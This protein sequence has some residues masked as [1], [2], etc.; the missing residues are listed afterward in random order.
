M[1]KLERGKVYFG[2]WRRP[3]R[4]PLQPPG[5][6]EVENEKPPVFEPEHDSLSESFDAKAARTKDSVDGRIKGAKQE[7]TFDR[8]MGKR[9]TNHAMSERLHVDGDI[10]E[11]WHEPKRTWVHTS[12]PPPQSLH[13]VPHT[14]QSRHPESSGAASNGGLEQPDH[15]LGFS[16]AIV[17]SGSKGCHAGESPG[18][19][20]KRVMYSSRGIE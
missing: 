12:T 17:R 3:R 6:H 20:A 4:L 1:L 13:R 16:S 14:S 15:V 2:P 18:E 5:D 11:L 8:D 10:G 7:W 19:C 9:A